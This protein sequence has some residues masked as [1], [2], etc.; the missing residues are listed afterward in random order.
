MTRLIDADALIED[1]T[2]DV[3]LD[4]RSLNDMDFVGAERNH[5]EIERYCKQ[6]AIDLIRNAET[7][8]AIPISFIEGLI[9][10]GQILNDLGTLDNKGKAYLSAF[11]SLVERWQNGLHSG[12]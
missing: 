5:I 12:D 10:G 4:S 2:Y 1:L 11:K 9:E 7:V 8:E 3:E 6:N